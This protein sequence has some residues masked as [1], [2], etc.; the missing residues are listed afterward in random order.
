MAY[1]VTEACLQC[2]YCVSRC[3]EDAIIAEEKIRFE[4]WWLQPVHIDPEKCT[5]C[6]VCV[7]MEYWC[8]ASAIIAA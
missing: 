6:G 3:P 1:M 2:G 4:R 7:S 8:P 5:D